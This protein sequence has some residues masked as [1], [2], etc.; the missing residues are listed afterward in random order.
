MNDFS[1]GQWRYVLIFAAVLLLNHV[2]QRIGAWLKRQAQL[3]QPSEAPPRVPRAADPT[4]R[5]RQA[6]PEALAAGESGTLMRRAE[7]PRPSPSRHAQDAR[8]L[9]RG[10]VKGRRNLRR[11]VIAMTVLGPCRSQDPP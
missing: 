1:G 4:R 7:A 3:Q 9:T 5:V 11:A 10:L 6:V 8:S 2:F